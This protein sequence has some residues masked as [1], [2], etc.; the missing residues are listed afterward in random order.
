VS[1]VAIGR[2]VVGLAAALEPVQTSVG[3]AEAAFVTRPYLR[4]VRR[5]GALPVILPPDPE[6][7]A[8]PD[9]G[10]DLVDALLLVGGSDVDPAHY[11]APRHPAT[12]P[13]V[14]ERD[15][16]ELALARAALANDLPL[17]GI[18]RGMQ[19]LNVAL[20]GTLHQHLP[21]VLGHS[22]HHRAS[23]AGDQPGPEVRLVKGSL[24]ARAAGATV[25]R[26]TASRHHQGLARVADRLRVTGWTEDGL[27]VAVEVPDARFVLGVQWHPEVDD[28]SPIVAALVQAAGRQRQ[29]A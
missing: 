1:S 23:V 11:G 26:A 27:P 13:P 21:E 14:P 17:L 8:D 4:H 9:A 12:D 15:L 5:A 18:C 22:H 3:P 10:L 2:P 7:A 29:A 20:G 28:A 24:A 6:L 25:L 16:A 19:L